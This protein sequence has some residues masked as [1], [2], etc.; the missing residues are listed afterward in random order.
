MKN[1]SEESEKIKQKGN[2]YFQLKNYEKSIEYYT[3]ALVLNENHILYSNRAASYFALKKYSQ[4]IQD[5]KKCI[6]L[7]PSFVKG[8]YRLGLAVFEIGDYPGA[9]V[10]FKRALEIEPNNESIKH[11]LKVT[12]EKIQKFEMKNNFIRNIGTLK[13]QIR[14]DLETINLYFESLS[15]N[16]AKEINFDRIPLLELIDN[17]ESMED[18]LLEITLDHE[19]LEKSM[20]KNPFEAL[21]IIACEFYRKGFLIESQFHAKKALSL[22][23]DTDVLTMLTHIDIYLRGQHALHYIRKAI[24]GELNLFCIKTYLELTSDSPKNL[25]EAK[26][27]LEEVTK[28][29]NSDLNFPREFLTDNGMKSWFFLLNNTPGCIQQLTEI[30]NE[31]GIKKMIQMF[32]SQ[33]AKLNQPLV[34]IFL[35]DF[36]V[37]TLS[38]SV[39]GRQDIEIFF[40]K[41]RTSFLMNY[42]YTN[43]DLIPLINGIAMQSFLNQ[44]LWNQTKEEQEMLEKLKNQIDS[45]LETYSTPS[46]NQLIMISIFSMY[47]PLIFLKN[48]KQLFELDRSKMEYSFSSILKMHL[49]EEKHLKASPKWRFHSEGI[50]RIPY[51]KMVEWTFSSYWPYKITR[52][53][54]KSMLISGCSTGEH[55]INSAFKFENCEILGIDSKKENI[56][57]S[58]SKVSK[59]SSNVKFSCSSSLDFKME[60]KFD[61]IEC[62]DLKSGKIEE[63]A[64]NLVEHLNQ[65]GLIKFEFYF[66]GFINVLLKV[67]NFLNESEE[68]GNF[69]DEMLEPIQEMTLNDLR[70]SRSLLLKNEEF[71][72]IFSKF[73]FYQLNSF[74]QLL[75][76]KNLKGFTFLEIESFIS[77]MKLKLI[78]V[79]YPPEFLRKYAEIC[80][81]D[82]DGQLLKFMDGY[83]G[84]KEYGQF[85]TFYCEKPKVFVNENDSD[86]LGTKN[87]LHKF[88]K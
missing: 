1:S 54:E 29:V 2:E 36:F 79:A 52:E 81:F 10:I 15:I 5:S 51:H 19:F 50:V 69:F 78:S 28:I 25:E 70:K 4:S 8:Y 37:K 87:F 48:K 21:L 12:Q 24:S 58:L 43:E 6:E 41:L 34:K 74:S 65:G 59:S 76:G 73:E 32:N 39:I 44:Y 22:K 45:I 68:F 26:K 61:I 83:E 17:S 9:S 11:Q 60:K 82:K 56:E 72:V 38:S 77:R 14:V 53:T 66:Q 62:Y 88:T 3:A 63:S 35:E 71:K 27:R 64:M 57:Y 80:P 16:K 75:C 7:N 47:S 86:P 20:S 18:K 33:N 13:G 23:Q 31:Y 49:S 67:R 84:T 30:L 40:V 85:L 42:E 55:V 46:K